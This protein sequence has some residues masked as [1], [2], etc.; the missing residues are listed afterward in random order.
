MRNEETG[1]IPYEKSNNVE[2]SLFLKQGRITRK[3]FFFRF[4]ICVT[5]WLIIHIGYIYWAKAEYNKFLKIGGGKIQDGAILVE[6]RYNIY[7]IVDFYAVPSL[8]AL[9]MLIQAIKRAHDSNRSGW[10]MLVPFYNIY[11][12]FAKGTN[13]DNNYGLLPHAEKK[14]PSYVYHDNNNNVK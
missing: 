11:L 2:T 6:T 7:R 9:F 5:I 8:L 3:A 10:L 1:S 4:F 13:E 12:L 14:S